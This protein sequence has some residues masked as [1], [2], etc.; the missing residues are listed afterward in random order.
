MMLTHREDG[1]DSYT[2]ASGATIAEPTA[3]LFI[4][5]GWVVAQRDF[6]CLTWHRRPGKRGRQGNGGGMKPKYAIINSDARVARVCDTIIDSS[7]A[8]VIIS[9]RSWSQNLRLEAT[10]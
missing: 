10:Q 4:R 7:C 2:D 8:A 6:R 5:N 9:C 3:R 1:K